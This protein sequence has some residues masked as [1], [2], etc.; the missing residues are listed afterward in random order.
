MK[1]LALFTIF[2][3]I[4]VASISL[5]NDAY[6]QNDPS[7]LLRIATQ[8]DKQILN[9][10]DR[11][12]DNSIPSKI[13]TLYEKGHSSVE[14][15]KNSLPNDIE[16]AREDFLSAMKS[17]KQITR[18]ISEPVIESKLTS[19][20]ISDKD[21]KSK[22]NRLHKYFQSLKTASEK[23]N[24]GIDF[25]EIDQLFTQANQQIDSS[26]IREATQTIQQLESSIHEIK[27][28]I[29]ENTSDSSSDRIKKFASKQLIHIQKI[30]D[31]ASSVDSDMPELEKANLLI[32]EI[33]TLISD[34]NI[35]DAKKKFG[36]LNKIVKTVKKSIHQ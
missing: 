8:A 30:L 29:R 21:L 23:H 31:K 5:V 13:Q 10:L 14:S 6:A 7:I 18:M 4:S 36:E 2:I 19:S 3:L 11:S 17:F 20:D 28:K 22:L 34:D 15:L 27:K 24:T 16:Q 26:E 25:S 32:Q 1:T 12:Y 33:K 35:S 9:Q